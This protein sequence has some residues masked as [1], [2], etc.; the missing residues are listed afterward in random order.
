MNTG[1]I[2]EPTVLTELSPNSIHL[3]KSRL[4]I[5]ALPNTRSALLHAV[6]SISSG[7]S[8]QAPLPK[9][10]PCGLPLPHL[11]RP[12]RL[13]LQEKPSQT[14]PILNQ[15]ASPAA[16]GSEAFEPIAASCFL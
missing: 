2:Q 16:L 7:H 15:N 8:Q 11:R 13:Q 10:S 14:D 3:V 5:E 12:F 6:S 1:D 4:Y 9:S